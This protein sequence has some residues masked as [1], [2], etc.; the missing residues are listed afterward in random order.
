MMTKKRKYTRWIF[1][2]EYALN[3]GIRIGYIY[4]KHKGVLEDVIAVEIITSD[5]AIKINMRLDEA[6]GLCAGLSKVAVQML[7][8]QLPI[9][10]LKWYLDERAKDI[11]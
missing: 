9:P 7:I 8:G 10:D 1:N 11:K 2:A 6:I 5:D 3:T 4:N